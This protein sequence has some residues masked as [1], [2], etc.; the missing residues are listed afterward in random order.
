MEF[1]LLSLQG[2]VKVTWSAIPV[3]CPLS[4]LLRLTHLSYG[5]QRFFLPPFATEQNSGTGKGPARVRMLFGS[6]LHTSAPTFPGYSPF[7]LAFCDRCWRQ[8]TGNEQ[9][10]MTTHNLETL[11]YDQRAPLFGV[12]VEVA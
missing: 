4:R 11:T 12:F 9:R 5:Q 7:L 8:L 6:V 3:T 2:P 10:F 1:A